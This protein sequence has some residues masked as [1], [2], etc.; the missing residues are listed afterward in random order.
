MEI[1]RTLS[2]PLMIEAYFD[3][4]VYLTP[5]PTQA[6]RLGY[7]I[8][9]KT[10]HLGGRFVLEYFDAF[11]LKAGIGYYMLSTKRGSNS[12]VMENH[13]E[14]S[15]LGGLKIKI[16]TLNFQCLALYPFQ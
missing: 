3:Y 6:E 4:D 5:F 8:S 16:G 14:F 1:G 10:M 12:S 11:I 2:H 15:G 9:M 13:P 7:S